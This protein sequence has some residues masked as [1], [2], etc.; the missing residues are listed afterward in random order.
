MKYLAVVAALAALGSCNPNP[1]NP[2]PTPEPTPTPWEC[3]APYPGCH[4]YDPPLQCSTPEKPCWHNPTDDPFHCE[5]APPCTAPLPQPQCETF[6][7]R[8]GALRPLGATCDCY[9]GQAW[10]GCPEPPDGECLKFPQGVP[11]SDFT[12][13]ATTSVLGNQVNAAIERVTRCT[14]GSNCDA[15]EAEEFYAKV[16]AELRSTGLWAGRHD[17]EPPGA[18]DEIAVATS[19]TGWWESYHIYNFGGGKVVWSPGAARPAYKIDPKWCPTDCGTNPTPPPTPPPSGDCPEP[20]PDM[21]KMKFTSK[22]MGSHLDTT[23]ITVGQPAYCASIGY[24]CMPGT[25]TPP[26]TCGSPGCI[27]RGG[28]PMRGDGHPD[29]AV[30]EAELCNQKW[31]CN[32]Q[33]TEGWRG[34]PAQTDC[35]GH[36]KT[37]CAA[38]PNVVLEGDR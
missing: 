26:N 27:P 28:C 30:C 18:S 4:E 1:P 24:C 19:C 15:G 2:Q 16:N 32:G 23:V 22:E 12:G 8:G 17:D 37:W 21:S 6:T 31:L 34:N 11:E 13:G 36:Y 5:E 33:P 14:T 7:D 9:F 35:R 29:R 20:H 38:A 10:I 3:P 25:G